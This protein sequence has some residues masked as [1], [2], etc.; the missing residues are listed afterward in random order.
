M[1]LPTL[2]DAQVIKTMRRRRLVR[3]SHRVVVGTREAASTCCTACSG[4]LRTAC[5]ERRN[6]SLH[7]RGAAIGRCRAPARKGDDGLRQQLAL[8]QG[9]QHFVLPP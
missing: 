9:Y 6:L 4:Q 5:V 3:G 7:Q 2:L 1:P 8:F